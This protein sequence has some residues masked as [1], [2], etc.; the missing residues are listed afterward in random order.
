MQ[1]DGTTKTRQSDLRRLPAE[2]L[3]RYNRQGP[4]YTSYPTAPE[5]RDMSDDGPF[6][7]KVREDAGTKPSSPI[8]LYFHIPFCERRCFFCAC[9]VLISRSHE[10]A[11]Q[12]IELLDREMGILAGE[13]ASS[14]G[15]TRPVSQVHLGGGTPNFLTPVQF[16][17]LL[18]H[19][20]NRFN[21][22]ID[23]EISL[24][25]DPV[26]LAHEHLE[27]L[28]RLGFN[29]IS[30]GVQDFNQKTQEAVNRVQSVETTRDATE[31][32]RSL[33]FKSVNYDLIYG[34]PYQTEATFSETLDI[35]EELRPDRI[36]LYNFAYLPQRVRHQKVLEPGSL[37][38]GP[39]KF[40]IF[41]LAHDRL[42]G[43]GYEYIGMDHYALPDD[44][45][46]IARRNRTL[47]RNF[48]GYTT[49]AGT[50]LYALG[51][52]AISMTDTLY[53]QNTKEAALYQQAI[54]N[55]KLPVQKG[56]VLSED[57]RI[58]R[59]AIGQLM[60][61][62]ALHKREIEALHGIDFDRY[63]AREL[64]ELPP[65]ERDGL[66]I[67]SPGCIQLTLLGRIFARNVAMVFDAYLRSPSGSRTFSR[68]L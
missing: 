25:A 40:R 51:V 52:S 26:T 24:E 47:Q 31:L 61:H 63:F 29:R 7:E 62:G 1:K 6:R 30:Y 9:N 3:E 20:R 32:A 8:S 27:T 41:T 60:C 28:A 45:L 54:E 17:R 43:A 36:A 14:R 12:Y 46:A 16:E 44:A 11:D 15:V 34:L 19:I 53:V 33:G 21:I 59:D 42:I 57:D 10:R 49:Q 58:R 50:D 13:M 39:E 55:A 22:G 67:L 4:R 5:W 66:I 23:A 56:M 2:F 35:V 68:T 65:M 18:G 38:S 37:P 64:E 48:M